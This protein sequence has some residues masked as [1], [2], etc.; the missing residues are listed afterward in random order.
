VS[1]SEEHLLTQA[2]VAVN[3]SFRTEVSLD[4]VLTGLLALAILFAV[5]VLCLGLFQPLLDLYDA[6]QTQTA[7]T[8]YWLMRGGPIFAYET[9]IVGFPWSIPFEFPLYQFIVAVV[10][11]AGI[12]LAAAGRI[13]SFVFFVGCLWPLR[14]LFRALKFDNFAF[15]CVSILFVLCPLY[16]FWSRT[17]MI[18]TCALFFCL[19]WLAYF[20]RYLAGGTLASAALALI[21]GALAAVTKFTTFPGFAVLGGLLLLKECHAAWAAGLLA[22]RLRSILLALLILAVPLLIAV[23]WTIY[24]EAVGRANEIRAWLT[25]TYLTEWV[26]GIWEQR[27]GSRLWRDVILHRSLTQSFGYAKPIAVVLI[28]ATL[29]RRQYAYA[30]LAA[31][32]AFL[33]PFMAFPN[34]HFQHE[35]YQAANTI[36]ILAAAGLGFAS[37]IGTGRRALGL[38][39]LLLIS[40]GQLDYFKSTYAGL[41]TA[42][43][44]ARPDFRIAEMARAQT[45]PGSSLLVI[46]RDWSATVGYY[47]Q[48]K[49]LS[50][51]NF[52]PFEYWQRVAA[53]PQK[54]LGPV[55]LAA[56]VVCTDY[57]P[58]DER[59]N[60]IEQLVGGHRVLG[61]TG[62]CTLYAAEKS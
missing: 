2:G 47:A 35:Y 10:S 3:R 21:A 60:L 62:D 55:P 37:I 20:A 6:R 39:F 53:Q 33:V 48:R 41:L 14:V 58:K 61:E 23:A 52:M 26:F 31:I 51:A 50:V 22:K 29:L 7:V 17:F 57:A 24:A 42:D 28:A 13:V 25:N 5:G 16:L 19:C 11:K 56:V 27:I 38:V 34:L 30:G 59:K 49:S 43:F 54:F 40:A 36:F 8:A 15:A 18:E 44:T 12:P 9:P 45:P 32:L 1:Q 46:G 4:R